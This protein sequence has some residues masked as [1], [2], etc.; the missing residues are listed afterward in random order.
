MA[1]NMGL[2]QGFFWG[3]LGGV[4]PE[5]Y[6]LYNMRQDFHSNRPRWVTSWFYWC[7]TIFMVALGGGAVVFYLCSGTNVS[8]FLAIHIGAATPTL[9]GSLI[10]AKPEVEPGG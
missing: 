2:W 10:K 5:F 6:V 9:I 7:V 8:P 1:D 3:L 4:L